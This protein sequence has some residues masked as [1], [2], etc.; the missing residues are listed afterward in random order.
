MELPM[1][2]R[3]STHR[4]RS[5]LASL[6]LRLSVGTTLIAHGVRHGRTLEGTARWFES[7]GFRQP[8]LQA[9]VSSAVEIAAGAALIAGAAT[10]VAASAIVGTMAV[11]A[12]TVHVP[13]GFFITGE[14][15]EYVATIG[16]AS[17]A[18]AALGGG[19]YSVDGVLGFDDRLSGG[20]GAAIAAGLGALGAAGQ[21]AVFWR[22]PD[23]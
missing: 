19:R 20:R 13:N 15:Y 8:R 23:Q 17:V 1:R 21:L 11:A 10:P 3:S 6:I 5:E 12:R 4:R 7:I 18:A 9:R 16:A 14:G 22:K 2:H